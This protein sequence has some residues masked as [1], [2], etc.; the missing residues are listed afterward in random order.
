[1]TFSPSIWCAKHQ[2]AGQNIQQSWVKTS[3]RSPIILINIDCITM[4][5]FWLVEIELT[6]LFAKIIKEM[7]PPHTRVKKCW[8]KSLVHGG[9]DTI[10][11]LITTWLLNK[12]L[13]FFT[14]VQGINFLCRTDSFLLLKCFLLHLRFCFT[15]V[16]LRAY[17][18]KYEKSELLFLNPNNSKCTTIIRLL[19]LLI[20]SRQE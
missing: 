12:Q 6:T 9:S 7:I 5:I 10:N 13:D 8:V 19:G 16:K 3:Y 2:N 20:L 15:R 1:M 11:S 14:F 18:L 4:Y 17:L